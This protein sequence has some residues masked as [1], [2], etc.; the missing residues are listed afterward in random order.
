MMEGTNSETVSAIIALVCRRNT[1][2]IPMISFV[3]FLPLQ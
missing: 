2:M 3:L 1:D